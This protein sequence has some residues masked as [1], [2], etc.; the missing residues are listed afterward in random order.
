MFG[1]TFRLSKTKTFWSSTGSDSIDADEF[2]CYRLKETKPAVIYS[3]TMKLF[4][5][6]EIQNVESVYGPRYVQIQ[7]GFSEDNY[8]YTSP[9]FKAASTMDEQEFVLLPDLVVGSHLRVNLIG[10]D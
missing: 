3:M 2:L 6:S 9:M 10:K 8:H 1:T 4:D 7:A 5:P